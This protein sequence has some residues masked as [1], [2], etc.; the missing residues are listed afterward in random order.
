MERVLANIQLAMIVVGAF[1]R[2]SLGMAVILCADLVFLPEI[3]D[4]Q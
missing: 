3:R 4:V 1:V 2:T